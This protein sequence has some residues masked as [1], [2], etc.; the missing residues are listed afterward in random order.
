MDG[1]HGTDR[2]SR[3]ECA[4]CGSPRVE[5]LDA[6]GQPSCIRCRA[7]ELGYYEGQRVAALEMVEAAIVWAIEAGFAH[8]DDVA[9]VAGEAIATGKARRAGLRPVATVAETAEAAIALEQYARL[10]EGD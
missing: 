4:A 2:A 5:A 1:P 8:P 9:R 6:A 10:A 3:L 7:K